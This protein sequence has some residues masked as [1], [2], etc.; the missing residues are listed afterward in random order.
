M[1]FNDQYLFYILGI[2]F[3][4]SLAVSWFFAKNYNSTKSKFL[5][6]DRKLGFF[7]SSFSISASWIWAP[8]LFISSLQAYVNGWIGLFWFCV[9]NFL[10]LVLFAFLVNKIIDRFPQGYTLSEYMGSIYSLRVQKLYWI[11]LL[12]LTL[13][14]FATQIL[15]GAKF[16]SIV[17]DINFFW[18]SVILTTLPLSYSLFFG[19]KSSVITDYL[20]IIVLYIIGFVMISLTIS[21]VGGFETVWKGISGITKDN[22]SLFDQKGWIVFATF[23]LPTAIGLLSGPFGD[24]AFWQRAFSIKSEYRQKSFLLA[25]VIFIMVPISMGLLGFAAAG[26]NYVATTK[27][28]VNLELVHNTIGVLG[29][30]LFSIIVIS[31]ITSILD[32]K[33]CAASS[34][35][36]HDIS[37]KYSL[38]SLLTSKISML[39]LAIVSLMIANIPGIEIVHLFLIYGALRA[40][41]LLPTL[42]TILCPE[43]V[44]EKG[45]FYGILLSLV[46]G[47]PIFAYGLLYNDP[48]ITIVGSL[49][50][51]LIPGVTIF[52]FNRIGNI[53]YA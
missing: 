36:G 43:K 14:A 24:Q 3:L 51:V 8:S 4:L 15:A 20:K 25:A 2:M 40:S 1:K 34:I 28:F 33:F 12:G 18:S 16:I 27:Q 30:V 11:S 48:T 46:V 6:A 10:A 26:L 38:D 23:G 39:V 19:L 9:P 49:G 37:S 52:L 41:T 17:S 7:E 29:T 35:A 31:S 21:T 32:S 47:I 50:G 13:G 22:L 42:M 45:V 5:L 44:N 53:K